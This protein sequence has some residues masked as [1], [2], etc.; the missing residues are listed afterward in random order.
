MSRSLTKVPP[1][2]HSFIVQE[3][4]LLQKTFPK[5]LFIAFSQT[6]SC[7]SEK[8]CK[9]FLSFVQTFF[10]NTFLNSLEFFVSFSKELCYFILLRVH[11]NCGLQ[12]YIIL[13]NNAIIY[14]LM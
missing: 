8:E 14:L 4:F 7:L 12:S 9:V 5:S 3:T 11:W 6:D 1:R 10:I 13:L 2:N